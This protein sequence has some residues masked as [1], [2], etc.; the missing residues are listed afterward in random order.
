MQINVARFNV[1]N[2]I[3][4]ITGDQMKLQK[5]MCTYAQIGSG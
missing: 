3:D 5:T 4:R 2:A 1:H